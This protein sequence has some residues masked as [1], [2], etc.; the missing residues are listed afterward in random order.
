MTRRRLGGVVA[1][2]LVSGAACGEKLTAPTESAAVVSSSPTPVGVTTPAGLARYVIVG[3]DTSC[4]GS[5]NAVGHVSER[6]DVQRGDAER[7]DV[8]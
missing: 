6:E 2:L 7:L 3:V 5:P 4:S 8:G 1:E